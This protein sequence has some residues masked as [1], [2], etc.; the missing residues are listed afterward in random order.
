[1]TAPVPMITVRLHAVLRDLAGRD[2]VRIRL[3][4]PGSTTGT[5]FERL[6]EQHPELGPWCDKVAFAIDRRIVG[7]TTV[8]PEGSFVLD[9]LPPVSGG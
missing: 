1:M 5:V 4:E 6:V 9:V 7:P 2:T 8:M 3:H